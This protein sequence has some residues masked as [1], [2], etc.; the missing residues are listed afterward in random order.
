MVNMYSELGFDESN[1]TGKQRP[2][3]ELV[4][5]SRLTTDGR[6]GTGGIGRQGTC[7]FP[8][9]HVADDDPSPA[10]V[11]R[12]DEAQSKL[13]MRGELEWMSGKRRRCRMLMRLV[14]RAAP[15]KSESGL[16]FGVGA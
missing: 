7:R 16:R 10:A 14:T 4:E 1:I 5:Y 13:E 11:A 9:E 15:W 3:T 8:A 12:V 2:I 6:R